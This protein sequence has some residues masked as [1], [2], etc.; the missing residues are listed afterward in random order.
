MVEYAAG[1]FAA[2][3]VG[4][5]FFL[6]PYAGWFFLLMPGLGHENE[7]TALAVR[8]GV[9]YNFDITTHWSL[10][11]EFNIEIPEEGDSKLIY[12]LSVVREF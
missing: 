3:V 4:V 10:A 5:S 11:P 1:D 8:A 12:G 6:H 9:G 2:W 7:E